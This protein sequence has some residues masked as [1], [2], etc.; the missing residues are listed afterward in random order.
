MQIIIWDIPC[1]C[2]NL[3]W[4]RGN[5]WKLKLY[6]SYCRRE[7][8]LLPIRET[9]GSKQPCEEQ[10]WTEI[11]FAEQTSL[12]KWLAYMKKEIQENC[13]NNIKLSYVSHG[14]VKILGTLDHLFLLYWQLQCNRYYS[15]HASYQ[16]SLWTPSLRCGSFQRGV[17]MKPRSHDLKDFHANQNLH[18]TAQFLTLHFQKGAFM[19]NFMS[20]MY[21]C[22]H[23]SKAKTTRHSL[24]FF[25]SG[26]RK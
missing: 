2:S 7:L 5:G 20:A 1:S 19:F 11:A 21:M 4:L 9:T 24:Q 12:Y 3:F 14:N 23:L 17:T 13:S 16:N 26:K 25:L 15:H 6:T 22:T 8:S 18:N 10:N